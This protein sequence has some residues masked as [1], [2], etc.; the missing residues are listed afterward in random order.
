MAT[1][2]L[3]VAALA[4]S[5]CPAMILSSAAYQA[6]KYEHKKDEP[7]KKTATPSATPNTSIE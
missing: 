6:Y 1:I 7:A 3:A 5:G 2:A 4:A